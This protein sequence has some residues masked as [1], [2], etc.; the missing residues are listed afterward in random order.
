[1]HVSCQYFKIITQVKICILFFT[2][3]DNLDVK[4]EE[5]MR[6]EIIFETSCAVQNGM[7]FSRVSVV[8]VIMDL[9]NQNKRNF[10]IDFTQPTMRQVE[11]KIHMIHD[12]SINI[13][14][15]IQVSFK[16]QFIFRRYK[17]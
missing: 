15:L 12:V 5:M 3:E 8:L 13:Q 4:D 6:P 9:K 16:M 10:K 11:R 2:N 17:N 7:N 1:M 14:F